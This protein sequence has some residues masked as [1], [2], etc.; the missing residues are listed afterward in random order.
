MNET[1]TMRRRYSA[2][3]PV[4]AKLKSGRTSRT[5]IVLLRSILQRT[6]L[7]LRVVGDWFPLTPLGLLTIPVLI[8]LINSY[9]V[10]RNDRIVLALG[11]CGLALIALAVF[12]VTVTSVWLKLQR[13]GGPKEPLLFEAGSP[14]R[15]GYRLGRIAWIPLIKVDLAWDQPRG[16][17]VDL[18]PL[19]TGSLEEVTATERAMDGEIVRR[20]TVSDVLGL[21][22][23][24]FRRRVVQPITIQ[25]DRGRVQRLELVRQFEPG[26]E[27]GHPEGKPEGDLI[28][29]RRYSA[30]DPLKY[31]LWK[32]YARTGRMLVRSP[33]RAVKPSRKTLV[34][35]VAG[36]SDEPAA[37]IARALLE[38]GSL[39]AEFWF[40]ADGQGAT[41]S[42]VREAVHQVVGSSNARDRG[43]EG[44]ETFLD[45][46]EELGINACI[47]FVPPRPG[48]WLGRVAWQLSRHTGPFRVLIGID[49]VPPRFSPPIL[50]RR[51]LLG[52]VSKPKTEL[53]GLRHVFEQLGQAGAEVCAV[54]RM[55]G[56]T[57]Q[58]ADLPA[59]AAAFPNPLAKGGRS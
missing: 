27:V 25:P 28:D 33:E 35:F 36:E 52:E 13:Q 3:K 18:V 50:L 47:L 44:L 56:A 16:I 42:D 12:L 32:V 49:G 14:F 11:C 55:S 45:R 40:R 19:R 22:R 8:V 23:V 43:G 38:G 26:D 41:T 21:A 7:I 39:G 51:F 46:G 54:D 9:G 29:M 6:G 48:E 31:V 5:G 20:F 57:C 24:K 2:D 53:S 34:Y 10:A 30:G 15:T 59:N 1:T 58:L 37:G 4:A 17:A